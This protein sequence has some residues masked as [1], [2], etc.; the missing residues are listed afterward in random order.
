MLWVSS[1]PLQ[2]GLLEVQDFE[3]KMADFVPLREL[4]DLSR[5]DP[6]FGEGVSSSRRCAFSSRCVKLVA[7]SCDTWPLGRPFLRDTR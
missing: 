3:K 2:W 6:L 7:H 1:C 4:L 5:D